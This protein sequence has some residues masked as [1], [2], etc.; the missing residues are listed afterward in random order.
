VVAGAANLTGAS[1]LNTHAL[2]AGTNCASYFWQHGSKDSTLKVDKPGIYWI[3]VSNLC[4]NRYAD[5]IIVNPFAVTISLGAD[6]VKCN[7]DTLHL[8]APSGFNNYIWSNKY[9]ISSLHSQ[10]V[11][12]N[13][14]VDTAYYIK[15]EKAPGC[16]AYDTIRVTVNHSPAVD[17]GPDQSFCKGD[18]VTFNAGAGFSSYAWSTGGALSTIT[19]KAAGQYQVKATTAHGCHLYDTVSVLDVW[20]L[21]APR[22]DKKTELCA[23]EVR[24]LDPGNFTSYQ[25]QDGS[26]VSTYTVAVP[27]RYMVQV[28]DVHGCV[29][30]DTTHIT[31]PLSKPLNFLPP[32]TSLCSY[33]TIVV[34]PVQN[35]A[36]YL[37]SDG[38]RAATL[39]IGQPGSYWLQV[40]DNNGCTGKDSIRVKAKDCMTGVYV[41]T[42]FSP[43]KDAKNDVF[44]AQV[45]G[46]VNTFELRVYNRWGQ[47]VFKTTDPAKG[48]DGTDAGKNQ[49]TGVFVWTCRYA[50]AGE[51]E[52]IQKGTVVLIR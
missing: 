16:F 8:A 17:L 19:V 13:P 9:N 50:M 12:V 6:R 44:R 43:N 26:T 10:K 46:P 31:T 35:F 42:A 27:G 25:W 20:E 45:F 37:W 47:V 5:T 52:K 1:F 3:Q 38:S 15:A 48:W 36:S 22:L 21:P 11:V 29:G 51:P 40:A 14:L 41:P 39:T 34:Q 2:H 7:A 28:K 49:D 33:S 23:G 30:Y 24:T 4:G 18:S 32:D